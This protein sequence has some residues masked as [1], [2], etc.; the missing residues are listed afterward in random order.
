MLFSITDL[1]SGMEFCS[2]QKNV[3]SRKG[4]KSL[5]A[6]CIIHFHILTVFRNYILQQI[7]FY[8]DKIPH[9]HRE[10]KVIHLWESTVHNCPQP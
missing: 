7:Y 10:A 3:L 5:K 6:L 2:F 4:I 1:L 9:K 8:L